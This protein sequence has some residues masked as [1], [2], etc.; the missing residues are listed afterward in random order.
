MR[1]YIKPQDGVWLVTPTD[2][3]FDGEVIAK[4]EALTLNNIIF[5]NDGALRGEIRASWGL[6]VLVSEITTSIET[7][8][9]IGVGRTFRSRASVPFRIEDQ[10][11]YCNETNRRLISARHVLL[12]MDGMFYAD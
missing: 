10:R 1:F 7:L 3:E 9:G 4:A 11:F 8:K 2:G 6:T 5:G 12:Y